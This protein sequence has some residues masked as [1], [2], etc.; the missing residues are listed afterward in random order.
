MAIPRA[1]AEIRAA[2]EKQFGMIQET[3]NARD[4]LRT[5][6]QKGSVLAY[7]DIF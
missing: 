2:L 5:L 1:W 6:V 7:M 4:K 3:R